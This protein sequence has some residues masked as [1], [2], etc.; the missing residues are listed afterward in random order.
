M[1]GCSSVYAPIPHQVI[2]QED[3]TLATTAVI[4]HTFVRS[5]SNNYIVCSQTSA[6]AAFDQGS[7]DG[8]SGTFTSGASETIRNQN[9]AND[10]EMSG[11]TPVLLMTRELMYR[12]CEFTANFNLTKVEAQALY[13][14]TLTLVGNVWTTEAGNTTIKITDALDTSSGATVQTNEN[15][16]SDDSDASSEDD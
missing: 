2:I 7:N 13:E 15:I 11:R 12:T 4:N 8:V 3:S 5:K 1:I 10:V 16:K 9:S 6:D 14:K